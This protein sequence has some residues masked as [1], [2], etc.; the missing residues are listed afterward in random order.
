[1]KLTLLTLSFFL[2]FWPSL[3][4]LPR[5]PQAKP[6]WKYVV[7]SEDDSSTWKTYYDAVNIEHQANNIVRVWLKQMPVTK[8]DAEM[9]RII[10]A[11]IANR[12]VNEMSTSGYEKFAYSLTLVEFDCAGRKGRSTAIKD[13]D[14]SEKPLSSDTREDAPFAPVVEHSMSEVVMKAA[15]K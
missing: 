11:I 3:A 8:T 15:C 13:Y 5:N 12:K 1:M 4:S 2:S 6:E 14:Q 10:S 7:T 9:Q